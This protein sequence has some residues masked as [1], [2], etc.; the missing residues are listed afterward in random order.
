MTTLPTRQQIDRAEPLDMTQARSERPV[1]ITIEAGPAGLVVRVDYQG[2][3]SSIPAA[4]EKLRAAGVLEL[5]IANK[6]VTTTPAA[7]GAAKSTRVDPEYN[8]AGEKCCPKH[9]K[10]LKEGNYGLYCSAKDDSTER[11]YCA[12]KFKD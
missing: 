4:I 9:H 5:V 10:A 1:S 3:L 11:G 2:T 6:P 8:G 12:L 7:P